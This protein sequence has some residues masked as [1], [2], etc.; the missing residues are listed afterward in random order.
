VLNLNS[1]GIPEEVNDFGWLRPIQPALFWGT[2]TSSSVEWV[3]PQCDSRSCWQMAFFTPKAYFDYYYGDVSEHVD[4]TDT[5][6]RHGCYV[7]SI[8][9]TEPR[10]ASTSRPPE[11]FRIRCAHRNLDPCRLNCNSFQSN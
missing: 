10:C 11:N 3:R 4:G 7:Y 9:A 8:F 2:D 6:P 5:I 1:S